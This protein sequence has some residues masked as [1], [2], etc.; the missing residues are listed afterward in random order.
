[1][2]FFEIMAIPKEKMLS[3][4]KNSRNRVKKRKELERNQVTK[5]KE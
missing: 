5:M 1:M 3:L 2:F 4:Q